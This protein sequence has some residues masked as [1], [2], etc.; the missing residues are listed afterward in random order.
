MNNKLLIMLSSQQILY[1]K[2]NRFKHLS[3]YLFSDG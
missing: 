2:K 1:L 3:D